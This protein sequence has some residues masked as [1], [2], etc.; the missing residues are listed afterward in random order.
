MKKS[1]G[2]GLVAQT[3]VAHHYLRHLYG[4]NDI[5]FT[6]TP[7]DIL[8]RL[9]GKV[10]SLL[11]YGEFLFVLASLLGQFLQAGIFFFYDFVVVFVKF[12]T[13]HTLLLK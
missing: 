2:D 4:V 9:I 13:F 1:R 12:R 7:S 6:G 5:R 3:Y 8:V 11:N 10:E